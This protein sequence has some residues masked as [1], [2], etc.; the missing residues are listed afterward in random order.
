M[1][2]AIFLLFILF[3]GCSRND[4]SETKFNIETDKETYSIGDKF[5]FKL[6]ISPFKEEQTIRFYK[7]F[8]NVDFSFVITDLEY[9]SSQEL[10]KYFIEGPS[11]FEDND[12]YIDEYT[13]TTEEPFKKTFYG[14]ISEL[15]NKI[16][17]EIPELKLRNQI[18]KYLLKENDVITIEGSCRT[19][20]GSGEKAFTKKVRLLLE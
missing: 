14:T 4:F 15:E 3:L 11:L 20:Y 9:N 17:F 2:K 7:T 5:Q 13:I 12:E 16:V 10:K 6:I 19:V 8:S 1:E 18:E